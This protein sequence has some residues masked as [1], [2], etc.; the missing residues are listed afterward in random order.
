MTKREPITVMCPDMNCNAFWAE[1]EKDFHC[2]YECPKDCMAYIVCEACGQKVWFNPKK[3][4]WWARM[5][6]EN[7]DENAYRGICN[8]TIWLFRENNYYWERKDANEEI[9]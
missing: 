6:C 3:H 2:K 8:A 9:S 1:T 7:P 5:Q 4:C